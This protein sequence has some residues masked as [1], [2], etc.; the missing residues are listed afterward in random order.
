V[1]ELGWERLLSSLGCLCLLLSRVLAAPLAA[2]SCVYFGRCALVWPV[3][4][5]DESAAGRWEPMMPYAL[6]LLPHPGIARQGHSSLM[7]G[8]GGRGLWRSIG[9]RVLRGASTQ[10][11]AAAR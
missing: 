3:V 11:L 1:E 5:V 10:A 6:L 9:V 2:A 8:A 4:G 7:S